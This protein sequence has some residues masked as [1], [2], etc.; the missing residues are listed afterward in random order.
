MKTLA[1]SADERSALRAVL[2]AP[3]VD[4][5]HFSTVDDQIGEGVCRSVPVTEWHHTDD[6]VYEDIL[7]ENGLPTGQR[8]KIYEPLE[9][10]GVS[11]QSTGRP[12]PFGEVEVPTF[13][14]QAAVDSLDL[15]G[16]PEVPP[17]IIVSLSTK[18]RAAL[19]GG[20]AAA[21]TEKRTP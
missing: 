18:L 21:T 6:A 8:R 15:G 16:P 5:V 19:S 9:A 20:S 11:V 13:V 3:G 12:N 7:D 2:D 4:P 10:C 17:G 14:V 1:L